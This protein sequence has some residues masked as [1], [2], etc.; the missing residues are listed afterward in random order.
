MKLLEDNKVGFGDDFSFYK[1]RMINTIIPDHIQQLRLDM[2]PVHY[3][4]FDY[5]RAEKEFYNRNEQYFRAIY[6]SIAPLLCVSMYQQI[7]PREAIYGRNMQR[8]SAF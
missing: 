2:N 1:Y 5:D 3:I 8:H 6:F 7:R 4:H